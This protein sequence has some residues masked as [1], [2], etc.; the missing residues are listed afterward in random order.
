MGLMFMDHKRGRQSNDTSPDLHV[1]GKYAQTFVSA[2]FPKETFAT[3]YSIVELDHH[4]IK[5]TLNPNKLQ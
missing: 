1:Q 2:N 3:R 5:S 4:E